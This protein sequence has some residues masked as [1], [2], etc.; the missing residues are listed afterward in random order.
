MKKLTPK[1]RA[2]IYLEAAKYFSKIDGKDW[3]NNFRSDGFCDFIKNRYRLLCYNFL[4]YMLFK[5]SNKEIFMY[6]FDVRDRNYKYEQSDRIIA[7]L[8]AYQM[9]LDAKE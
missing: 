7:L 4:E 3:R 9:A 1:E 8:F 2:K 5:P 6:W